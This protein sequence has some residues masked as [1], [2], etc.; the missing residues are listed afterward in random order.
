MV[1]VP[2]AVLIARA[3]RY[4]GG[5]RPARPALPAARRVDRADRPYRSLRRPHV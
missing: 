3:R 5:G 2:P 4:S 1:S